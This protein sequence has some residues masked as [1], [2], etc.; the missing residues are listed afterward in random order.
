MN[1]IPAKIQSDDGILKLK[2]S[3][4]ANWR[5]EVN[6]PIHP[7]HFFLPLPFH[8]DPIASSVLKSNFKSDRQGDKLPTGRGASPPSARVCVKCQHRGVRHARASDVYYTQHKPETLLVSELKSFLSI[9][10]TSPIT[11]FTIFM[12]CPVGGSWLIVFWK[13]N[14]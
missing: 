3:K 5:V 1:K 11:Y 14:N 9:V 7:L 13:D 4:F 10:F 6:R 8:S 12:I 2:I